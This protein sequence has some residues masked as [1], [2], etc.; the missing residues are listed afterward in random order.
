[1]RVHTIILAT[2]LACA[3]S[4]PAW[5]QSTDPAWLDDL[6]EQL[7]QDEQCMVEYFVNIREGDLAGRGTFEARAQCRDGRQFDAARTEP[8]PDFVISLCEQVQVC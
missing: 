2:A 7:A 5:S 1:M 8:E 6:T 4:A 3:T